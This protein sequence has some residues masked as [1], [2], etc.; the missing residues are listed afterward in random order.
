MVALLWIFLENIASCVFNSNGLI[1]AQSRPFGERLNDWQHQYG[2]DDSILVH[3]VDIAASF[4]EVLC[5]EL[6]SCWGVVPLNGG[7]RRLPRSYF[8]QVVSRLVRCCIASLNDV[9]IQILM[10]QV[11]PPPRV[12]L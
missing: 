8:S 7:C 2:I 10:L 4:A 3:T 6:R 5:T 1:G 9:L 12:D 11:C